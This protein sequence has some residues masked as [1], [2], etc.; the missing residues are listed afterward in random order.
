[1]IILTGTTGGLGAPMLAT[2]LSQNLFPPSE[3][4]ISTSNPSSPSH[5]SAR[6]AGI[7]IRYGDMTKPETLVESYRGGE[8]LYLTSYPSVGRERYAWH[9]NCIDAAREAG[10]KHVIYTSLLFGGREGRES[11]A[12]VMQA[13][14]RTVEYLK[15][16]GLTWKVVR[17]YVNQSICLTRPELLTVED[18]VKKYTA[19]TNRPGIAFRKVGAEKAIEYHQQRGSLPPG[20][21]SFLRD[22]TTWGEALESGEMDFLDSTMEDLLGR[23][24]KTIDDL[25]SV[26]FEP[27]TNALDTK[28]FN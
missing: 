25:A 28:D 3:I 8:V 24:L 20:Q 16:S 21:E 5:A 18:V 14:L 2:L 10:V 23:K 13:H 1:M 11:T 15:Q 4:I 12:S 9:R 22:W 17:K 6:A 7:E 26:L 19:Y 27:E